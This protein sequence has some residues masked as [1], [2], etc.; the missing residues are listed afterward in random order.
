MIAAIYAR[1]S[2]GRAT[3]ALG[4]PIEATFAAFAAQRHPLC[5]TTKVQPEDRLPIGVVELV[6]DVDGTDPIATGVAHR[7]GPTIDFEADGVLHRQASIVELAADLP[8]KAPATH[9]GCPL[10]GGLHLLRHPPGKDM[11][12]GQRST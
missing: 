5:R 11:S 12:D 7:S 3:V 2:I 9:D 10:Y 1:K 6:F 8:P 4:R